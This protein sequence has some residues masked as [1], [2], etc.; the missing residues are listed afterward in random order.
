MSTPQT[1][2]IPHQV[3]EPAELDFSSP[4]GDD[5]DALSRDRIP[6]RSMTEADL[7]ALTAIDRR[8]T[9]QDRS[10]YYRRKHRETLY[11]AGVRVSLVAELDDHPVGFIM[12]RVD[13][14]E[15]GH[16]ESEAVM[17]TIGVDPGY[18]E[19]GVGRALMSQLIANLA[20]LRVDHIRTEID[21]NDVGLISYLGELGFEPAQCV[22][23]SR[24]LTE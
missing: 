21:W 9:E 14:G 18:R 5:F 11:E 12:A 2:V 17:D 24:P 23:L 3:D 22:A 16:T 1:P 4:Q 13:F 19:R 15:F 20:T 6:V 8:A 10:A 7:E